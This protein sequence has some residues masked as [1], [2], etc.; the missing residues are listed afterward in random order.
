MLQLYLSIIEPGA[1][2]KKCWLIKSKRIRILL[3][4]LIGSMLV[5]LYTPRDPHL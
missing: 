2:L 1:E 4:Y 5:N 3:P